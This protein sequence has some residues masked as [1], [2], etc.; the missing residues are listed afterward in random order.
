MFHS[1]FSSFPQGKA[2]VFTDAKELNEELIY[3]DTTRHHY[4]P[5]S[6]KFQMA[7]ISLNISGQLNP[8]KLKSS[9]CLRYIWSYS[10]VTSLIGATFIGSATP[11]L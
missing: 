9:P 6:W 11:K 4:S 8:I 3:Y 2:S 1:I 5:N 10:S 7:C